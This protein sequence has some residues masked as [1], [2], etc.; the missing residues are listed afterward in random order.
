MGS[1]SPNLHL[2]QPLKA[3]CYDKTYKADAKYF[4]KSLY[5]SQYDV[6]SY[7]HG[8]Y[9]KDAGSLGWQI[10]RGGTVAQN[11]FCMKGGLSIQGSDCSGSPC[12]IVQHEGQFFGVYD[13]VCS[14]KS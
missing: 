12:K 3:D 8:Q 14:G 10:H 6:L 4:C 1:C 5:G 13:L 2:C 7:K 11:S 9:N